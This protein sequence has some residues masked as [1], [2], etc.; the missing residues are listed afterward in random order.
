MS[1]KEGYSYLRDLRAGGVTWIREDFPWNYMEPDRGR[2]VWKYSD[3]LMRNT[4]KLGIDVLAIA[5]GTPGW[6]SGRDRFYY[7]P[8]DPRL[9][10]SFVTRV[11]NRYGV[12]GTFWRQNPSL[13]PRPLKAIEIWNEP[14][15]H[16]F[17]LDEPDPAAYARL[18]RAA[19]QAVKAV[20]PEIKVLASADVYEMRGDTATLPDWFAPLLRADPGL[21]RGKLVDAWSV[22]LYCQKLSPYDATA[23]PR[24]RFDRILI[25]KALADAAR[26]SKPFWITEL[27]WRVGDVDEPTQADFTSQSLQRAAGEWRSFVTRS[28]VYVW[29]SRA[30]G[31]PYN[32]IRP[33]GSTRPAWQA[34]KNLLLSAG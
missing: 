33:D 16:D 29:G 34:M 18:V 32:L 23:N 11:V 24:Y 26:A 14:W 15:H 5:Y 22:H 8:S 30:D 27:G 19:A 10:A 31:S 28:F 7:P 17:W 12:R 9:Y 21:W 6:A 20:H 2:L 4:A 25:S 1:E 3:R 13:R